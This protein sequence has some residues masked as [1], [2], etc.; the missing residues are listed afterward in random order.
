M[1]EQI[2]ESRRAPRNPDEPPA[3]PAFSFP[4]EAPGGDPIV[5]HVPAAETT[6]ESAG[7][8]VP[9]VRGGNTRAW[10]CGLSAGGPRLEDATRRLVRRIAAE[11]V[12]ALEA[13]L[14]HEEVQRIMRTDPMR[15]LFAWPALEK[16]VGAEIDR[17]R[18]LFLVFSVAEIQL[19]DYGA[20]PAPPADRELA[21]RR[22]VNLIQASLRRVDLLSYDGAGRFAILLPRM[23]KVQ[24][25]EQ[26]QAI[27]AKLEHDPVASRLL[28]VDRLVTVAPPPRTDP[29]PLSGF[30]GIRNRRKVPEEPGCSC[31]E[32]P[33]LRA[34]EVHTQ[35]VRHQTGPFSSLST[36]R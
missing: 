24:A 9:L 10:L 32:R 27:V 11:G 15:S 5:V 30:Q 19:E 14:L 18:Q 29:R 22:A 35:W 36:P 26:V 7:V 23:P 34:V 17:C 33:F 2:P 16:L 4:E 6:P 12:V 1:S 25:M 31:C 13:A 8:C 28:A 3:P 20:G 21:L